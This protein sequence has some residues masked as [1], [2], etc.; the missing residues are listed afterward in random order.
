VGDVCDTSFCYVVDDP[1][2]CLDPTSALQV[3]AGPDLSAKVGEKVPL[4]MWANRENRAIEYIWVVENRPPGSKAEIKH[5]HGWACISYY[6]RYLYFQDMIPEFKPDKA[7]EY[8]LKLSTQLVFEDD[9]YPGKRTAGSTV[10]LIANPGDGGCSTGSGGGLALLVLFIFL[11]RRPAC[12][13]RGPSGRSRR[14]S[15]S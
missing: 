6:Y 2:D 13:A 5:D 11:L 12:A 14:S 4:M 15:C 7:G 1:D 3:I 10:S 9:L 8:I